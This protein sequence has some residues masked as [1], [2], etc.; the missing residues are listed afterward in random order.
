MPAVEEDPHDE[1]ARVL[2]GARVAQEEHPLG[3]HGGQQV[4]SG[5]VHQRDPHAVQW[6]H[7]LLPVPFHLQCAVL[8]RSH[9]VHPGLLKTVLVKNLWVKK[10]V[11]PILPLLY[12]GRVYEASVYPAGHGVLLL[13]RHVRTLPRPRVVLGPVERHKLVARLVPVVHLVPRRDGDLVHL[14]RTAMLAR[15]KNL[16]RHDLKQTIGFSNFRTCIYHFLL[17]ILLLDWTV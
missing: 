9:S 4:G 6:R 16:R 12:L 10:L 7:P 15:H 1:E 5:G 17:G 11:V 8:K 3:R 2:V 14:D 13:P